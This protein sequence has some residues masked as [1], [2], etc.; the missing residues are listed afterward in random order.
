MQAGRLL[1][2]SAALLAGSAGPTHRVAPHLMSLAA[3]AA[4][5]SG[6]RRS[7]RGSRRNKPL[8]CWGPCGSLLEGTL[9]GELLGGRQARS[10]YFDLLLVTDER[11][12]CMG[13]T[14]SGE[15]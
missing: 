4:V 5:D 12:K 6:S 3:A 14:S 9:R 7:E 15:T 10:N 1:G 8:G 13:V 11:G 2:I